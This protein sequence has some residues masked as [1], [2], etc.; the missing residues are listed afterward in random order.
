MPEGSHLVLIID[1]QPTALRASLTAEGYGVAEAE[2]GE[3]GLRLAAQRPP[4][5]ADHP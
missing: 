2:S 3:G 4:D 1:E 5:L